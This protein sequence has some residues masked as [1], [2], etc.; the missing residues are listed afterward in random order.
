MEQAKDLVTEA[1]RYGLPL[2]QG[3]GPAHTMAILY[4]RAGL[5]PGA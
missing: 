2:G 1:V 4:E 5:L 3:H